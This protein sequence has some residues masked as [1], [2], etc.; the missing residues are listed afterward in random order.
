MA[1][2]YNLFISHSWAYSADLKALQNLLNKRGYFNVEYLKASNETPINS[3]NAA[4]VKTI[5]KG[6]IL[7]SDLVLAVAAVYATYSE[8]MIW[9]LETAKKNNIPIIGV[10]PRGQER[11]SKE[12]SS[13]SQINVN[14]NTES[15]VQAIRD[16]A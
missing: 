8:W 12:V 15:I 4:Y 13:R 14:W 2:D 9:E 1:K 7:K 6:K 16:F 5:L 3:E 10:I 11:I